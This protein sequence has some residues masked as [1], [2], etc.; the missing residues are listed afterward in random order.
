LKEEVVFDFFKY[1]AYG[2]D[3]VIIDGRKST[4]KD[5]FKI[6]KILCD[7][8]FSVGCDDVLYIEN[9]FVA[10]AKMRVCEPDGSESS[11]CGNGVRCVADYL[12]KELAKSEVKI[13]TLGGIKSVHKE[14]TGLYT[15]NMGPMQNVGDFITPPSEEI[16]EE[17]DFELGRFYIV[18]PGEPHAVTIV[19]NVDEIDIKEALEISKDNNIFPYGINVDFFEHNESFLKLRTFERGIWGETLSCG[20][21]AVSSAFVAHIKLGMP[22]EITVH[23]KGGILQVKITDEGIFLTG[24]AVFVFKGNINFILDE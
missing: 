14:D 11:M 10:D 9:S 17:R 13:E 24:E 23:T 20:T 12:M 8:H 5:P 7:R 15:V 3:F 1:Q 18:S 19:K 16:I 22:N 21:G 4:F 2:N 6:S